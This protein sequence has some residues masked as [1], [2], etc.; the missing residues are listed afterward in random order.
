M[1]TSRGTREVPVAKKDQIPEGID[2]RSVVIALPPLG[3]IVI[4]NDS[5]TAVPAQ[6][7]TADI[8]IDNLHSVAKTKDGTVGASVFRSVHQ[9]RLAISQ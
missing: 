5:L 4:Q 9:L 1:P 3:C 8:L 6:D 7:L 2:Q